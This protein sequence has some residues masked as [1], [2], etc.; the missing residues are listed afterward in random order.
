MRYSQRFF[1]LPSSSAISRL[2]LIVNDKDHNEPTPL[3]TYLPSLLIFP[4]LVQTSGKQDHSERI[5]NICGEQISPVMWKLGS[6]FDLERNL[7]RLGLVLLGFR[8]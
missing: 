2:T 7:G 4:P 8:F 1:L 3:S 5:V 6:N